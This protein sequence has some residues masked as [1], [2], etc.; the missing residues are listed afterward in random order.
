VSALAWSIGNPFN[1][2]AFATLA[3][4]LVLAARRFPN[5]RV[6]FGPGAQVAAG[7]ALLAFGWT[8]PHFVK[9]GHWTGYLYAAPL[10]LLPCP[11][12]SAAIGV[13]LALFGLR[14]RAWSVALAAVGFLY[15]V[16]G[17]FALGVS[18][19]YALLG[20]AVALGA[21]AASPLSRSQALDR[22]R[23]LALHARR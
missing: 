18:L 2:S 13:T 20:G 19:D 12:L 3:L 8:Y 9:V 11:T 22:P 16:I 4:S 10:G 1:G 6:E 14:S 17:V 21:V 7:A 5:R 23:A 15:G